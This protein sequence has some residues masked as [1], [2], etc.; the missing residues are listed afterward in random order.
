MDEEQPDSLLGSLTKAGLMGAMPLA[1]ATGAASPAI[2]HHFPSGSPVDVTGHGSSLID[3]GSALHHGPADGG[4]A[5]D[6]PSAGYLAHGSHDGGI[7]L[8]LN[9][10]VSEISK[11]L[12]NAGSFNISGTNLNLMDMVPGGDIIQVAAGHG[13]PTQILMSLAQHG[14]G[15]GGAQAGMGSEAGVEL[16]AHAALSGMKMTNMLDA[17]EE[18]RDRDALLAQHDINM[19]T[20]IETSDNAHVHTEIKAHGRTLSMDTDFE[21]RYPDNDVEKQAAHDHVE[22]AAHGS[23][24]E[25]ESEGPLMKF[26][27]VIQAQM[28][29][30]EQDGGISL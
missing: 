9:D 5:L 6:R 18:G 8:E 29:R 25:L 3:D 10:S 15:H 4:S 24:N 12:D 1:A 16:A 23:G 11:D 19:K 13:D 26:R 28:A 2:M 21:A 14:A 17:D 7:G 30:D 22:K 27:S 20:A